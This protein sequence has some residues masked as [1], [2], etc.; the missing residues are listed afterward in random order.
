MP[1]A[2]KSTY[3]S[4]ILILKYPSFY[5]NLIN[6]LTNVNLYKWLT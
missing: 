1:P 2:L 3:A 5:V 4:K 6:K